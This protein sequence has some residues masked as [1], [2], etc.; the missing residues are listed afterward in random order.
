MKVWLGI[1]GLVFL[2]AAAFLIRIPVET[3]GGIQHTGLL[4]IED[5]REYPASVEVVAT[6]NSDIGVALEEGELDFGILSEGMKAHK[7]IQL[8]S[9][10][11]VRIRAWAEGNISDIISFESQSFILD[12]PGSLEMTVDAAEQGSYSGTI[13]LSSSGFRSAWLSWLNGYIA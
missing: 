9:S 12:G 7:T 13:L 10:S 6:T 4:V 5:I 3:E 11:P 1:A 8:S 2:F